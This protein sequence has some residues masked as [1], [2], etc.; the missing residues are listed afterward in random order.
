MS[1]I[2]KFNGLTKADIEPDIILEGAYNNLKV[3]F[4]L[5]VD[6]NDELYFAGSTS[7]C[8]KAVFIAQ[9]FIKLMLEDEN[10]K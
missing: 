8:A 3:C 9:K 6:R 5:G 7:D 4:V 1:N 2:I 10:E